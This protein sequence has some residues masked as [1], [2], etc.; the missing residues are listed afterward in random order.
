MVLFMF[1]S[2]EAGVTRCLFDA[3]PDQEVPAPCCPSPPKERGDNPLPL[4]PWIRHGVAVN[5]VHR[6]VVELGEAQH[7]VV[8]RRQLF[9]RG[10]D[11]R[12]LR[13]LITRGLLEQ[14]SP[15]VLRQVGAPRTDAQ[16][17]MAGVL[18]A[19]GGGYLSHESAAAWWQVPGFWLRQPIHVIIPW[20]GTN[21]RTRLAMMHYHRD[22]PRD[23]LTT[24]QGVP[25][26]SPLLAVFL[27]ASYGDLGRTA[28]A[29]DHG[30]AMRLF[31]VGAVHRMV[32]RLS[33]QGRNG[34]VIMRTLA[35][36]RPSG[37]V[38][39]QSGLEARVERLARD[40]G[41][42]LRRQVDVGDETEWIGRVDFEVVG[43]SDVIEVLSE[44]YHVSTRSPGG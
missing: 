13:H 27:V 30:L 22:L 29:L 1:S 4:E 18:D 6:L 23:H 8:G 34:M 19:P 41:V 26:V 16:R 24:V 36:E 39:P 43:C 10:V 32:Q 3:P 35:E 33:A 7:G 20:K 14:L 28:R 42:E 15:Q 17:A 9:Q 21:R 38:A 25:V 2:L 37:Y 44:R 12:R 31:S 11:P 5:E 40:V